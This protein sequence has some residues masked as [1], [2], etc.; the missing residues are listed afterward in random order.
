MRREAGKGGRGS[1]AT[2]VEVKVTY[3]F[4]SV[5]GQSEFDITRMKSHFGINQIVQSG[6]LPEEL[7]QPSEKSSLVPV[8][9]E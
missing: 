3:L 5:V 4:G 1:L 8:T 7:S 2:M 9:M 6:T